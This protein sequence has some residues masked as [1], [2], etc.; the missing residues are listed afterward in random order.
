MNAQTDL[1]I[2]SNK[3]ECSSVPL[4]PFSPFWPGAPGGQRYGWPRCTCGRSLGGEVW[5]V[6][7]WCPRAP[8]GQSCNSC[9]RDVPVEVGQPVMVR[10]GQLLAS[11]QAPLVVR[12]DLVLAA[13]QH[14]IFDR[15]PCHRWDSGSPAHRCRRPWLDGDDARST[16]TKR[17][18]TTKTT[19]TC[20]C[21]HD[22]DLRWSVVDQVPGH[23]STTSS[24]VFTYVTSHTDD[25]LYREP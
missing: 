9:G 21:R 17:L 7:G 8:G 10:C 15:H 24:L 5:P 13:A 19:M 2:K 23:R 16:A 1:T 3:P 22:A 25:D 11:V 4:R 6:V 12:A 20:V 14:P 18:T